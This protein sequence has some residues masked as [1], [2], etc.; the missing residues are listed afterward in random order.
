MHLGKP[1][2]LP[3][4]SFAPVWRSFALFLAIRPSPSLT[5]QHFKSCLSNCQA[6][7]QILRIGAS[8]C[9][10][11]KPLQSVGSSDRWTVGFYN[12][13]YCKAA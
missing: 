1:Q 9:K 10:R 6:I 5:S 2:L 7:C 12:S 3:G 13:K 4:T 8:L 11:I